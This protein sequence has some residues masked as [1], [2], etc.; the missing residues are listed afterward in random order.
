M[1]L[2]YLDESGINYKIKDRFYPD[3]PF[4]IMGAMFIFEDVYWNIERLFTQLIDKYFGIDDWLKTEVHATDIWH[5]NTI[6]GRVPLPRRKD[7]FDEFS[8][9]CGKFNLPYL[10]SFI[11]KHQGR[12]DKEKNL[13]MLR[14]TQCLLVNIEHRLADIHQTGVLV[15]DSSSTSERLKTVDI[16]DIDISSK[17]LSPAQALLKIFYEMTSWRS[18]KELPS[19][20]IHPKYVSEYMSAYLIDRIHFLNSSDS[21][22]LQMCDIMT[23]LVQRLI[24]HDYLLIADNKRTD[25]DKV[26]ISHSGLSM[27]ISQIFPCTYSQT[28]N[29]VSFVPTANYDCKS[30][31]LDFTTLVGFGEIIK[32]HYEQLCAAPG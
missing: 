2:I 28:A 6:F 30:F 22:F 9:L 18:T 24:T 16:I 14:A 31:L 4:L 11:L 5:G 3:G 20:T 27:M 10:F 7:F 26:P 12:T 13:D 1:I 23:F 19:F 32:K 25:E 8:Q 29:D 21:L 15:C 17:G